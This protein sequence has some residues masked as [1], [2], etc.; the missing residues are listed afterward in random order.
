MKEIT[1][2]LLGFFKKY[3]SNT[4]D[5]LINPVYTSNVGSRV[6]KGMMFVGCS[7]THGYG[8]Q[9]YH[10]YDNLNTPPKQYPLPPTPE[11]PNSE[12]S[13][14]FRR[15]YRFANIV[16]TDRN[17]WHVTRQGVSGSDM[18]TLSF[19]DMSFGLKEKQHWLCEHDF[20]FNEISHIIIQTSFPI[21]SVELFEDEILELKLE[22]ENDII[23]FVVKKLTE[24]YKEKAQFLTK[25]GIQVYFIHATNEYKE[26]FSNDE[27][28]NSRTILLKNND[29]EYY[30][31]NDLMGMDNEATTIYDDTDFF[32]NDVVKDYHP[33]LITHSIIADNILSRINNE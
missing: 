30:C 18:D 24:L 11:T 15:F 21:R 12:A 1:N 26:L 4:T 20:Q 25:Q 5:K 3:F 16:A 28:L 22:S 8:L 2:N 14:K 7:F 13:E 19:L 10:V 6:P 32:G 29:T 17:T 9:Y 31:I 23:K 27:Y 33:S